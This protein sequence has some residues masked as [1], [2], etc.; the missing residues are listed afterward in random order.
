MLIHNPVNT[1][2][3]LKTYSAP[4]LYLSISYELSC[5]TE[6]SLQ[7]KKHIFVVRLRKKDEA[8]SFIQEHH[9]HSNPFLNEPFDSTS[10]FSRSKMYTSSAVSVFCMSKSA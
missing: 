6:V 2:S 7:V 3:S 4:R 1:V 10:K 5:T 9:I 8:K